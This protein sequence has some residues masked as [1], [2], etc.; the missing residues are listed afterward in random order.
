MLFAIPLIIGATGW[1]FWPSQTPP[2]ASALPP[3]ASASIVKESASESA[4][5]TQYAS[6][7]Q[8]VL[9]M[10]EKPSTSQEGLVSAANQEAKAVI[11]LSEVYARQAEHVM[12]EIKGQLLVS[13]KEQLAWQQFETMSSGLVV[14]LSGPACALARP[15]GPESPPPQQ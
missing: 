6:A 13:E 5:R 14:E 15:P 7:V 1:T 3:Q 10:M 12:T 4:A 11:C 2:A 9:R 8:G